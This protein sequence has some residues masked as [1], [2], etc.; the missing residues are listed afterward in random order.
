M[1]NIAQDAGSRY[2]SMI[3]HEGGSGSKGN[4]CGHQPDCLREFVPPE[5]HRPRP[6]II[7]RAI[8][9]VETYFGN[10]NL[11]PTLN[12]A[13]DSQRQQR[14]ERREACI[15]VLSVLLHYLD[16]VTMRVAIPYDDGQ[17]QG[18][19]MERIADLLGIG[20]KRAERAVHDLK[21]AGITEVFPIALEVAPDEYI[22]VA[23]IRTIP[24]SLFDL[25]GIGQ[26]LKNERRKAYE[27]QQKRARSQKPTEKA[28]GSLDMIIRSINAKTSSVL[29]AVMLRDKDQDQGKRTESKVETQID[30]R[31][32]AEIMLSSEYAALQDAHPELGI[33]EVY[34]LCLE[35][36]DPRGP[37]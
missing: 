20:L 5:K 9:Q 6:K 7:Q 33:R 24:T 27:R 13:N 12:N 1:D 14:S 30:S 37:P 10:P 16:L 4:K 3:N 2:P 34:N 29:G 18:I 35:T 26:W 19:T 32:A 36:Y 17:V 22:G 21:R 23:A 25:L 8:E 28:K 15:G 31:L 11:L